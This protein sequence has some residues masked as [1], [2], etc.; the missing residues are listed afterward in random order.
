MKRLSFALAAAMLGSA[1]G[2]A[3]AGSA[4]AEEA[5]VIESS[6]DG[7]KDGQLVPDGGTIEVPAGK[8]VTLITNSGQTVTLAGPYSGKVEGSGG[9]GGENQVVAVLSGLFQ[10]GQ[11]GGQ[12]GATRSIGNAFNANTYAVDMSGQVCVFDPA[13]ANIGPPILGGSNRLTLMSVTGAAQAVVD[14]PSGKTVPWPAELPVKTGAKYLVQKQGNTTGLM[15][16][17]KVME[18]RAETDLDR[19]LEL[20]GAGCD[21]QALRLIKTIRAAG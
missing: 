16:T 12:L 1:L 9:G 6:V 3:G 14:V 2:F 20:A 7:I 5:I 17:L 19:V 13:K 18:S 11:E 8:T 21:A 10:R 15:I 4:L